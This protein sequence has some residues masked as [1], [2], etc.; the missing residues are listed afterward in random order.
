MV[1]SICTTGASAIVMLSEIARNTYHQCSAN[2]TKCGGLRTQIC[3]CARP[4]LHLLGTEQQVLHV[5][6]VAVIFIITLML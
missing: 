1:V 3:L 4:V 5:L 6:A 2:Q